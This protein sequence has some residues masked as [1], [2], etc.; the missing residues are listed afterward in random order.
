MF[1]N[2]PNSSGHST[3]RW[4]ITSVIV[5]GVLH[6]IWLYYIFNII[7]FQFIHLYILCEY[8]I[9]KIRYLDEGLYFKIKRRQY[10]QSR[11][12]L[13][14]YN[15]LFDEINEYNQ[16]YWSKIL[17]I[18]WFFYGASLGIAIFCMIF[19]NLHIILRVLMFYFILIAT[20]FYIITINKVSSVNNTAEYSYKVFQKFIVHFSLHHTIDNKILFAQIMNKVR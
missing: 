11:D 20:S 8:L 16:T 17:I 10:T 15:D 14:A 2:F 9:M 13:V 3:N 12:T 4:T 5:N 1:S 19:A 18:V 7:Y 6:S